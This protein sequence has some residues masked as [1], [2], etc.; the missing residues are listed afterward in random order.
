MKKDFK[1]SPIVIILGFILIGVF[2]ANSAIAAACSASY[3]Y[4]GVCDFTFSYADL[5]AGTVGTENAGLSKC[6]WGIHSLDGFG[7]W[8]VT[9]ILPIRDCGPGPVSETIQL[10]IGMDCRQ[11]GVNTCFVSVWSN[12]NTLPSGNAT[13]KDFYLN[14][15]LDSTPPTVG[16]LY[17]T[18][19][20]SQQTYPIRVQRNISYTYK[21]DVLDNIKVD[22]C[23]FY[24][25]GSNNGSMSVPVNCGPSGCVASRSLTLSTVANYPNSYA[26]CYDQANN[27]GTGPAVEIAVVDVNVVLSAIPSNGNTATKF[28]LRANVT[29]GMTGLVNY[30]F[31]CTN[32]GT[33]EREVYNIG[34][35]IY[36]ATDLCQY[37]V[38]TY[39]AKV[40]VEKGLGTATNTVPIPVVSN[41]PP[42][43]SFSCDASLCG[44]G[45]S[46]AN[47]IGYR[48]CI[49]SADNLSS[50]PNG[51][52]DINS[53][54]WVVRDAV[55]FQLKDQLTCPPTNILC[56]YA[57]PSTLISNTYQV[58]ITVSDLA[59]QSRSYSRNVK[60][61]NDLSADFV[62]S[63][64][65][66]AI[67]NTKWKACNDPSFRPAKGSRVYFQDSLSDG[68]LSTLGLVGK[69][70][71][72][73]EDATKF[74][75]KI[76]KKDGVIFN[77]C[78]RSA[79]CT[80]NNPSEILEG[81]EITLEVEDDSGR[82]GTASSQVAT[83]ASLPEWEEIIPF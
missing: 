51:I 32:N 3:N 83:Q 74:V 19:S 66:P 23:D 73:S 12:D 7:N 56:N 10:N 38:G 54:T 4:P 78:Q 5:P 13:Q 50:D 33:W 18:S 42:N 40:Y 72:L 76:W 29:G 44:A 39:T 48:G 62:C 71:I 59:G 52:E 65:D 2:S 35:D 79:G 75:K 80:N 49:I 36:T 17:I 53:A 27:Q 6:L 81:T 41:D 22:R 45:S 58:T 8:M 68:L 69:R 31:D 57:L 37:S 21:V 77:S 1:I 34:S 20:Q 11:T 25:A 15:Q 47:C 55:F 28:S 16:R 70:S 82:S 43:A 26:V 63:D 24:L 46:S 9:R 30:K 60:L 67:N 61:R 64:I 14:V